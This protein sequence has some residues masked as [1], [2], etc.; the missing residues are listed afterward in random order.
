MATNPLLRI[1]NLL[2]ASPVLVGKVLSHDAATDTS[3]IELPTGQVPTAYDPTVQAGAQ[4]VARG[5]I[6]AVGDNAFV[7][8]GVVESQAPSQTVTE[9]EI[10][11]VVPV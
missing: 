5:R 3:V 2:P 11:V 6:V 4:F 10:G 9:I 8:N 1:R 7:R